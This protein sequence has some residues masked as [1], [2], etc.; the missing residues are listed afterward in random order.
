V[1]TGE[2]LEFVRPKDVRSLKD[3]IDKLEQHL[4]ELLEEMRDL[5]L[6]SMGRLSIDPKGNRVELSPQKPAGT[7]SETIKPTLEPIVPTIISSGQMIVAFTPEFNR[8]RVFSRITET[9]SIYKTPKGMRAC[10]VFSGWGS[11]ALALQGKTIS[12]L[13]VYN[14]ADGEW[15]TI[16]VDPPFDFEAWKHQRDDRTTTGQPG[17]KL[18]VVLPPD[19]VASS[20]TGQRGGGMGGPGW[21]QAEWTWP[22]SALG[23]RKDFIQPNFSAAAVFYVLGNRVY[24]YAFEA[25]KWAV[26]EFEKGTDPSRS[27]TPFGPSF[28]NGRRQQVF[29][30]SA[31][32]WVPLDWNSIESMSAEEMKKFLEG[33]M[34]GGM[35]GQGGQGMM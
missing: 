24:A 17:Q 35:G 13:A 9:W 30:A 18:R 20:T 6:Q 16:Q 21:G 33:G 27:N 25:K 22:E 14:A 11:V 8:F 31:G 7:G 3:R 2:D 34:G 5:Q 12:E 10:P 19:L 23:P 32:R 15:S 26:A 4:S 28:S 1:P 29:D